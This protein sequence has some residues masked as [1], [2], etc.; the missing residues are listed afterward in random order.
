M[1][2]TRKPRMLH[3]RR[4]EA[5]PDELLAAALDLFVEKGF[6]ATR[7]DDVAARAGVT[8]GTLY[9]YFDSKVDLLKAVAEKSMKPGLDLGDDLLAGFTGSSSELLRH[10]IVTW[11]DQAGKNKTSGICKLMLAEAA[12][13]PDIAGYFHKEVIERV[14]G[15]VQ[16]ALEIGIERGEFRKLD[17]A[18]AADT[19]ISPMLKM[20]LW[21]HS[22]FSGSEIQQDAVA[23]LETHLDIV[24]NGVVSGANK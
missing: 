8:K 14:Q 9:L 15:Q 4:K 11:W 1:C 12:N 20:T 23:Y 21:Q 24:L 13:F 7:M 16:K 3:Q 2:P 10:L 18:V 5:R 19:I 17:L 6:A 22:F